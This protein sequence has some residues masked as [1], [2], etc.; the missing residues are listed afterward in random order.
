MG[1]PSGVKTYLSAPSCLNES[2]LYVLIYLN[3]DN[4]VAQVRK[5]FF[6]EAL[7]SRI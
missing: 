6:K 5:D 1:T 3:L 2:R 7:H 4:G